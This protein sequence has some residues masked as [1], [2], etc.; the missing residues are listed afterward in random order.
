MVSFIALLL[1]FLGFF[2]LLDRFLGLVTVSSFF[3]VSLGFI[4]SD[5]HLVF[6]G[7]CDGFV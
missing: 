6:C 5:S 7:D 4:V 2:L 1:F 3:R